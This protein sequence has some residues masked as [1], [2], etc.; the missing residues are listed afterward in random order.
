[1]SQDELSKGRERWHLE[2]FQECYP[3]ISDMDYISDENPD[4]ILESK[5]RM[6]GIEHRRIVKPADSNG[7]SLMQEER[8]QERTV[9]LACEN[10]FKSTGKFVEVTISFANRT[11]INAKNLAP[12][13]AE[14]VRNNI[15]E[16][17]D[18]ISIRKYDGFKKILPDD[19]SKIRIYNSAK[20]DG[21]YWTF[22]GAGFQTDLDP[23]WI[24]SAI[25]EKNQKLPNYK[26]NH[27]ECSQFW[28]L[29]VKHGFRP[30]SWF[31][32]PDSILQIQ[33]ESDFDKVFLLDVQKRNYYDLSII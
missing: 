11:K 31:D 14:I 15:P 2:I 16:E 22:D 26:A 1:M 28:L 29:L 3:D 5:D 4:F 10:F 24:K 9:N 20:L 7:F 8:V 6:L 19:V 30:S 13:I 18:F 33:F 12:K 23:E 27:P 17:N 32:I 21:N 25:D